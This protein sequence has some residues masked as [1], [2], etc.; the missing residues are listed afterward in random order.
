V[1]WGAGNVLGTLWN[2]LDVWR[3]HARAPVEGRAL[4]RGHFLAEERPGEVL[5]ELLRFFDR[6]H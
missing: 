1:P 4:D 3:E 5:T 2:V 6:E